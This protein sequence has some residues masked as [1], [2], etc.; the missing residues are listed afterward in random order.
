LCISLGDCGGYVNT[1]GVYTQ[2]FRVT[3][4]F[5]GS[6]PW[7]KVLSRTVA[8]GVW[9]T[10]DNFNEPKT[11]TIISGGKREE[12]RNNY[13]NVDIPNSP[14]KILFEKLNI[15]N[16]EEE[17]RL[18]DRF[19]SDWSFIQKRAECWVTRKHRD[20]TEEYP[21]VIEKDV[22]FT[23][24]PWQAPTGGENCNKCNEG[25][26]PCTEY[27]C[28]SLGQACEVRENEIYDSET[29]L[30]VGESSDGT[31]PVIEFGKI[32]GEDYEGDQIDEGYKIR[33]FDDKCIQERSEIEFS[34]TTS[35]L[36]HCVY[37]W[38]KTIKIEN[39]N[40]DCGED[41]SCSYF[42]E[43][44]FLS[45][46][47][48]F[49]KVLPRYDDEYVDIDPTGK[50]GEKQGELN[51]YVKCKNI[52]GIDNP[53]LY[54]INFCIREGRDESP[55]EIKEFIPESGSYLKFEETSK[56]ITIK[57]NEAADCKWAHSDKKY[58]EMTDFK[59]EEN[60]YFKCDGY[61]AGIDGRWKCTT[62]ITGLT[63]PVND[64]YIK[65]K[66]QPWKETDRNINP[67]GFKYTL[68]K[69]EN[70]LNVDSISPSGKI[71]I[72]RNDNIE[73]K[74]ETSGGAYGGKSKCWYG[75]ETRLFNYS[76]EFFDTGK[77]THI[78]EKIR[79]S[80]GSYRLVITCEDNAEN[81]ANSTTNFDLVVDENPPK[82]IRVYEERG[83]LKIITNEDAKC[84]FNPDSCNFNLEAI[85]TEYGMSGDVFK[86]EHRAPW[87]DKI[88]YHIKCIDK[89]GNSNDGCAQIYIPAT[90]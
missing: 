53:K 22:R 54:V 69:T 20:T 87:S 88:T 26:L 38:D 9:V 13:K 61:D 84:Y 60:A 59:I 32:K 34:L 16:W 67:I 80:G 35:E 12:Y 75:I 76:G 77:T 36:A 15:K 48:T 46:T 2:N 4:D 74:A 40:F 82:V 49:D 14:E 72:G 1:E 23:C 47:H 31:P 24:Q 17:Y 11:H 37:H 68:K 56:D 70:K 63:E 5:R 8:K 45:E 39:G 41:A 57:L 55:A 85:G 30:C 25:E 3:P 83:D 64:I 66:D 62:N 71:I 43:G 73:L 28:K 6:M 44:N 19:Y 81:T 78:Q 50:P 86:K 7:A 33:E 51:M 65:C 52:H 29:I 90:S 89:Y 79:L 18:K 27:K 42:N 10:T 21:Y 58:D